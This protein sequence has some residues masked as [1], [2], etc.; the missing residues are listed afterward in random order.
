MLIE[1]TGNSHLVYGVLSPH[2]GK[3][4]LADPNRLKVI[5]QAK[6]K[7]DKVDAL[8]LAQLLRVNLVPEVWV[9]PADMRRLGHLAGSG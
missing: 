3:V 7:T 2:V 8:M 6:M 9:A 5:S 1:A 4:L